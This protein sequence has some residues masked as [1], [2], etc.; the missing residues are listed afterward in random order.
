ML[1]VEFLGSYKGHSAMVCGILNKETLS[2]KHTLMLT[3]K[4]ALMIKREQVVV[5]YF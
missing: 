4:V 3:G 5:H 2:W 1:L